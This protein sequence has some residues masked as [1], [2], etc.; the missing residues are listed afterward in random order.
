[1][2][3]GMLSTTAVAQKCREAAKGHDRPFVV[4]WDATDL[5]TF[6]AKA[7][8]DTVFVRYDGCNLEVVDG[9]ADAVSPGRFGAYGTPQFTS[10]TTQGFDVK[11]QGELYAK[12]P[13]GAASLSGKVAAGETL[14]LSTSCRVSPSTRGTPSTKATS[15]AST[16]ARARRN[17]SRPITSALSSS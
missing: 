7:A 2:R 9:C 17:G 12:L 16:R 6:E 10:G 11:N 13:L 1:G 14:H 3:E 5:A 4:E 15:K 8:R